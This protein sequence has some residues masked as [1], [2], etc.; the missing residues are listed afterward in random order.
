M[1]GCPPF[2]IDVADQAEVILDRVKSF[3][4]NREG[5]FSGDA[6]SGTFSAKTALGLFRGDYQTHNDSVTIT[7]T[8]KPL[9]APCG[10]IEAAIRA[11]LARS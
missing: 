1:A 6:N 10:T 7:I 5:D 11:D 4:V 3:V 8:S 9:I 2:D